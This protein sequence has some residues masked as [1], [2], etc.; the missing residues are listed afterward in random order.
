AT[1][2]LMPSTA[3]EPLR[4]I[5]AASDGGNLTVSHQKSPSFR[6][7]LIVPVAST[8]PC[9]KCPPTRESARIGRSRFTDLP[10]FSEPSADTRIVSG[11]ISRFTASLSA[12]TTVRQTPLTA[13]ESPGVSSPASGV[14]RR[15]RKP[16]GV[17][18]I[19]ATSPIRSIS[20]VNID[21]ALNEDIGAKPHGPTVPQLLPRDPAATDPLDSTGSERS[22]GDIEL[23]G[24]DDARVERSAVQR[25][26]ALQD[27]R[28]DPRV[29]QRAQ[30]RG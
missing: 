6:I 27:E 24:V 16:D 4:T 11:A 28:R 23:N 20:P 13:R 18:F 7:S 9:T 10:G 26:T 5:C 8:C 30:R 12:E 14:C 1:V 15:R 17:G 19:S 2:R 22:R 29:F 21:T 25:G 3:M